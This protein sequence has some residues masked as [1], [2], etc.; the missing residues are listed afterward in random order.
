MQLKVIYLKSCVLFYSAAF[1]DL[2]AVRLYSVQYVTQKKQTSNIRSVRMSCVGSSN[3][4]RERPSSR[5]ARYELNLVCSCNKTWCSRI[6]ISMAILSSVSTS[7][8]WGILMAFKTP[9]SLRLALWRLSSDHFITKL[10]L[11]LNGGEVLV[12]HKRSV[13]QQMRVPSWT[14]HPS[15]AESHW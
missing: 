7:L 11:F 8:R 15:D 3:S 5:R 9:A 1:E 10:L 6:E 14:S 12:N 2:G 13:R 4:S